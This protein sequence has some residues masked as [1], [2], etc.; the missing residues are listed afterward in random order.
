MPSHCHMKICLSIQQWSDNFEGVIALFN[1]EYFIKRFYMQLLSCYLGIPSKL[2]ML[3]TIWRFAYRYSS[4]IRP[5]RS[6]CPFYLEYL[7][8]RLYSQLLS[9]Y[10]GILQNFACL[11]PYENL[12][13]AIAVSSDHLWRSYCPFWLRIFH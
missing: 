8:K 6:Y 1:L 2:C 5:F 9:C 4:F 12:Y 3:I 7:I 11:L 13:I 10:L